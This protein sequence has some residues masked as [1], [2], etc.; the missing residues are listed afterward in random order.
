MKRHEQLTSQLDILRKIKGPLPEK[1]D[2]KQTLIIHQN[3]QGNE[4]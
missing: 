2:R 1:H 4:L 3:Q